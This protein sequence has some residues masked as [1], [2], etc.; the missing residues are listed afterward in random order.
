MVK[1]ISRGSLPP[2]H[3]I[4]NGGLETFSVRKPPP[5][6]KPKQKPKVKANG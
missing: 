4:F 6:V 2:D 5:K 1:I 3:P